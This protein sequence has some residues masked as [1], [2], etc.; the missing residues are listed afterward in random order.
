VSASHHTTDSTAESVADLHIDVPID[1]LTDGVT[2]NRSPANL[3]ECMIYRQIIQHAHQPSHEIY[4]ADAA[5]FQQ[6]AMSLTYV[7]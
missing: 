4:L 3:S 1:T 6:T 7:T 2:W 5:E